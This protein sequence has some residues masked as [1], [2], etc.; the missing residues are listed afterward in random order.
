MNIPNKI[1]FLFYVSLSL[2]FCACKEK[3]SEEAGFSGIPQVQLEATKGS[4]TWYYFTRD[5]Y[6]Q[7]SK[8]QNVPQTALIPWT[9]AIRISSANCATTQGENKAF[10]V[11]NRLGILS[12]NGEEKQLSKDENIFTDRTAGNL[13]FLNETPIFSVFKSAFFNDTIKDFKYSAQDTQ[14]LF[15]I[16]FDP[17]SKISYPIINCNNLTRLANSEIVDYYWDGINW[18]CC[19]KTISDTKTEFNYINWK[20]IPSLLTLSPVNANANISVS[21]STQEEFRTKKEQLEYKDAPE[22]IKNLLAG[23]SRRTSFSIDVKNSGGSSWRNY[24][25]TAQT[26]WTQKSD[27]KAGES[28]GFQTT[29]G[30]GATGGAGTTGG[31]VATGKEGQTKTSQKE[32]QM[33]LYA[34]AILAQT[35]AAALFEDGTLFLE[36]ALP[37]KHILRGGKPVAIRLPKLPSD[38]V[39]SDFVISGTT[40]YAAWEESSFFKTGRAGFIEINLNKTLY[41]KL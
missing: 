11:I 8:I 28:G 25:N 18:I 26:G 34:T 16:Q 10:A 31:A 33:E 1:L 32:R 3:P 17:S 19:I 14:H 29:D 4:H 37:G 24:K 2:I 12:F 7:V 30:V 6:K 13:I 22:R 21:E 38:F 36:G 5:G 20:P 41:S 23:F 27:L 40:L 9:E 35:W 39:Y 15:L